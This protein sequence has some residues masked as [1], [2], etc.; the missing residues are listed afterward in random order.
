[1]LDSEQ[2]DRESVSRCALEQ[3]LDDLEA[4]DALH[5]DWASYSVTRY[6]LCGTTQRLTTKRLLRLTDYE[7]Q[8]ARHIT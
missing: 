3:V 2:Q 6:V 5:I 7:R 4:R 1:M 8:K